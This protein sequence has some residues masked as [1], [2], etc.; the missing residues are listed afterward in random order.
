VVYIRGLIVVDK[1][2]YKIFSKFNQSILEEIFLLEKEVFDTPH[3]LEELESELFSKHNALILIAYLDSKP[4]GFK[5]GFERS[6][7]IF[8]SWIGG[9]ALHARN[10]SIAKELMNIQHQKVKELGYQVICT[11]TSNKFKPMLIL[12]LSSGFDIVGTLK[13]TGDQDL[14]LILEKSL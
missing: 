13:S 6:N 8:Y 5:V 4:V 11:Q 3:S 12:N 10:K 1:I 14:T 7:R 2:E 9:V